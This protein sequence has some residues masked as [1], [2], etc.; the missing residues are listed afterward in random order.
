MT[1]CIL[2]SK[3]PSF[4][5]EMYKR[6]S[7]LQNCQKDQN[8]FSFYQMSLHQNWFLCPRILMNIITKIV[9][10]QSVPNFS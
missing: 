3:Q 6:L 10:I 9:A 2:I 5:I 4:S 7:F 1:F 8:L